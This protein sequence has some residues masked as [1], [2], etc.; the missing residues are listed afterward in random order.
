M[1]MPLL[2]TAEGYDVAVADQPYAN[3]KSVP[4]LS[5]YDDVKGV[6]AFHMPVRFMEDYE[7]TVSGYRRL[8]LHHL[9]SYGLVRGMAAPGRMWLYDDANYRG[10]ERF[11]KGT[12]RMSLIRAYSDLDHL[13]EMTMITE[14]DTKHAMIYVNYTAHDTEQLKL[15]EYAPAMYIDNEKLFSELLIVREGGLISA[16]AL[17]EGAATWECNMAALLK[18]GEWFLWLKENDVYDNTRIILAADHGCNVRLFTGTEMENGIDPIAFNP[19]LMVKDF[20]ASGDLRSDER[21]MTNADAPFLA[22][23]GIVEDPVNPATG[24]PVD[25]SH[26]EEGQLVTTSHNRYVATN[27]KNTYDTSD[28]KWYEVT[29]GDIFDAA[30]WRELET[31]QVWAP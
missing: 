5:I 30:N 23:K 16:D 31:E 18:L 20:G 14:D 25:A 8:Q 9:F 10:L 17:S 6:R 22:L 19:L 15:P 11:F 3:Y 4:D 7:D 28:G 1:L 26:R 27:N 29:P 2:L 13:P 12:T 21:F 24:N